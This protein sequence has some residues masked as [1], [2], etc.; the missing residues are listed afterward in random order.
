MA[1]LPETAPYFSDHLL[2][3][4][5]IVQEIKYSPLLIKYKTYDHHAND[6]LRLTFIPQSV[7]CN[8]HILT[9]VK[10]TTQDLGWSFDFEHKLLHISRNAP[11]VI[12]NG[13]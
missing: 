6:L 12:I 10:D 1:N 3:S 2:S 9:E 7:K 11:E 5:S 8:G 4:T 13:R